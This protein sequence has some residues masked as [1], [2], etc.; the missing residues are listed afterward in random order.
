MGRRPEDRRGH[1][2][3]AKP[4][5]GSIFAM[6]WPERLDDPPAADV[7][8]AAIASAAES[9]HPGGRA[10]EVGLE[11]PLSDEREGDDPH[12]LLRVVRAV[13]ERDEPARDE[14][15]PPKDVVRPSPASAARSSHVIARIS[16][17]ATATRR[18][19]RSGTGISTL[20]LSPSHWTTSKPSAH[21]RRAHDAADERMARARRQPEVP[22]HEIPGDRADEPRKDD[23]ER[24]R[25]GVDDALG[26][27]RGDRDRDERAREVEDRRHR[28]RQPG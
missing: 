7:G 20:S 25:V 9:D 5:G 2:C 26:D 19:G 1:V 4:C 18:T 28:D 11:V 13:G 24:D 8:P 17:N 21:H 22:R 15:E 3:A 10:P 23:V 6:R 12:R 16:R 14:L 27:R